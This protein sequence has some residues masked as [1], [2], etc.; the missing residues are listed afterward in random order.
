MDQ[1]SPDTIPPGTEEIQNLQAGGATDDEISNF[2]MDT[3]NN[4]RKGGATDDEVASYYGEKKVDTAPLK[5]Q[6][7]YNQHNTGEDFKAKAENS[8]DSF[9]SGLEDS[10]GGKIIKG[11]HSNVVMPEGASTGQQAAHSFGGMLGD[12]PFFVGGSMAGGSPA[13]PT[14]VAA[15]FAT[16]YALRKMYDDQIDK[17]GLLHVSPG[18]FAKR[19]VSTGYEAMKGF[20]VGAATEMTGGAGKALAS[21]L[22]T[23]M[24]Q[25]LGKG[26]TFLAQSA[27]METVS[28]ALE[29]H[30]PTVDGFLNAAITMGGIEGMHYILPKVR[31][32]FVNTGIKLTDMLDKA[33]EDIQYKQDMI[34]SNPDRPIEAQPT[35]LKTTE[36]KTPE[37]KTEVKQDAVPTKPWEIKSEEEPAKAEPTTPATDAEK[38]FDS[39]IGE[40]KKPESSVGDKVSKANDDYWDWYANTLDKSSAL[41]R[42]LGKAGIEPSL[43]DSANLLQKSSAHSDVTSHFIKFGTLDFKTNEVTGESLRAI[44]ADYLKSFPDDMDMKGLQRYGIAARALELAGREKPVSVSVEGKDVDLGKAQELVDANKE[45]MQPMLDR[46]VKWEN[47]GLKFMHDSGYW[48]EDQY[49]AMIDQ[50]KQRVSFG[51]VQTPDEFTG[52]MP[53]SGRSIKR[54]QGEGGLIANPVAAAIKNMDMKVR[55]AQEN[56]VKN[57]FID[58]I[59]EKGKNPEEWLEK[60]APEMRPVRIGPKDIESGMAQNGVDPHTANFQEGDTLFKP[61]RGPLKEGEFSRWK[62][63]QYEVYKTSPIIADAL[64]SMAGNRPMTSLFAKT[65]K[66]FA[67]TLRVMTVNDPLFGLRHAWKNEQTAAVMSQTG[68]KPFYDT[69]KI[70]PQYLSESPEYQEALKN[71]SFMSNTVHIDEDYVDKATKELLNQDVPWA[72][73][74][75][76]RVNTAGAAWET[77]KEIG[78][79]SHTLI[80]S[81][82]NMIRM[83]E[84]SRA[85]EQGMSPEEA[86]SLARNVIPDY[87]RSGIKQ[88]ALLQL[89]PFVRVHLSSEAQTLKAFS[90]DPVGIT[91]KLLAYQTLPRLALYA[92]NHNDPRYQDQQDWQK[93]GFDSIITDEWQPARDM[94]LV[95]KVQQYEGPERAG[96]MARKDAQGNWE[97]NQGKIFR[98]PVPFSLGVASQLPIMAMEAMREK[99]PK[100]IGDW[101]KDLV[102]SFGSNVIP[103]AG[104]APLEHLTNYSFFTHRRLVSGLAEKQLPELEQTPYTSENAKQFSKLMTKI[105]DNWINPSPIIV[106]NYRKAWTGTL[107]STVSDVIDGALHKWGVGDTTEKPDKSWAETPFVKSMMFRFPS[108]NTKDIEDFYDNYDKTSR[109]LNSFK[110]AAKNQDPQTMAY[111]QNQ[112]KDDMVDLGGYAKSMSTQIAT[113]HAVTNDPKM[114]KEDKSQMIDFLTFGVMATAKQANE[115]LKNVRKAMKNNQINVDQEPED[116]GGE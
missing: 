47:S 27:A 49:N 53:K 35:E 94:R 70:L 54:I 60:Q 76:N 64:N 57:S 32:S 39:L 80:T 98:L 113:I 111:I 34:A 46:F 65:L 36:T 14:G 100:I 26:A 37:G 97:I 6:I 11:Q 82:D 104:L 41:R 106:D 72:Q 55:L 102:S 1:S 91:L 87:Q 95:Q 42:A 43:E 96:T 63:G 15:G 30:L 18:E 61:Q 109:A 4:L 112:H 12:L 19:I 93:I 50:N 77:A 86:A 74:V 3:I 71:K 58:D 88:S 24:Q 52:D 51:R 20:T 16:T 114:S 23:P 48:S 89:A 108:L 13:T 73:R 7:M 66:A 105:T 62:D 29:N 38:Y 116:E 83:A 85:K 28:S 84:Y 59:T 5:K 99:D 103:T 68:F 101:A 44:K 69:L 110:T 9:F 81:H 79:I 67:T 92:A 90:N 10:I 56:F 107:G 17:G 45:K 115:K 2:K 33:S 21:A 75:W 25:A 78:G 8:W 31:S 40:Q 22:E